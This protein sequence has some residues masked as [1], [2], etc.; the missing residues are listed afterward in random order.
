MTKT[1]QDGRIV[2]LKQWTYSGFAVRIGAT[3]IAFEYDYAKALAAF[4]AAA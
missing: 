3:L 4:N 2:S 1:L